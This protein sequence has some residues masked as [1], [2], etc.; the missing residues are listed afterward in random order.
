LPT[1]ATAATLAERGQ[2]ALGVGLGQ[3]GVQPF[4]HHLADAGRLPHPDRG[5]DHQDVGVHQLGADVRPLVA[6]ALVG[7]DAELDA[8][9]GDPDQVAVDV[10][11]G[12]RGE[13]L[14][15]EEFAARR[16]G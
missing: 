3:L 5:G 7:G 11:V 16:A 9:V 14:A 10:V 15:A 12:E 6:V 4:Q 8:V 2:P 1:T 13:H